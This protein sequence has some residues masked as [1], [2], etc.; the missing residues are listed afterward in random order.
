MVVMQILTEQALH[1]S[2]VIAGLRSIAR[3]LRRHRLFGAHVSAALLRGSG[4]N[5]ADQQEHAKCRS[6]FHGSSPL[7]L[8]YSA[9]GMP[10]LRSSRI[11]LGCE[12]GERLRF[13]CITLAL[14][15]LGAEEL[16]LGSLPGEPEPLRALGCTFA[17]AVQQVA[18]AGLGIE[19]HFVR[20]APVWKHRLAR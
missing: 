3:V 12:D 9:D 6:Q 8:N 7:R 17:M 20:E 4:V 14:Q 13:A 5:D 19:H 15:R 1:G 2:E 11:R 10:S 18:V 16:Q